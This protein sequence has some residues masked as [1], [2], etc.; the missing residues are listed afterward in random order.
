MRRIR[1]RARRRRRIASSDPTGLAR[2]AARADATVP[3]ITDCPAWPALN[4]QLQRLVLDGRRCGTR[5]CT[6]RRCSSVAT[7]PTTSP[8]CSPA[9]STPTNAVTGPLPWLPS[10]PRRLAE[11]DF[12]SRYFDRRH[13]LIQRHGT[14]VRAAATRWTAET[15]PAWTVPMLSDPDLIRDLATWRAAREIPDTDLRPTGPP[16]NGRA[17]SRHQRQLDGRL[18][19]AGGAPITLQPAAARLTEAIHPGITADPHWP[20]LARQIAAAE[21]AGIDRAELRRIGHQPTVADRTARRRPRVPPHRRDRRAPD[22]GAA[23]PP[24][25]VAPRPY[26]PAPRTYPAARPRPHDRTDADR[27]ARTPPVSRGVVGALPCHTFCSAGLRT[28][29]VSRWLQRAARH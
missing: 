20:N 18:A 24:K 8:P 6:T 9:A 26:E 14:A 10:V 23:R 3:G 7:A 17:S 13:E 12:W 27:P 11:D 29:G 16:A 28:T 2:I 4:T 22:V 15:A 21:R 5:C 1:R 19:E 25:P